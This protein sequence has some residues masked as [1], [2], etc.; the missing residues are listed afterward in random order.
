MP[1][2][3]YQKNVKHRKSNRQSAERWT[4]EGMER[5]NELLRKVG[6]MKEEI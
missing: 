3:L 2:V 1:D 5:L 6:T 4:E